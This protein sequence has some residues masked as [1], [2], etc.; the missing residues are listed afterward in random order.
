MGIS[1][2]G[3]HWG[4]WKGPQPAKERKQREVKPRIEEQF[5]DDTR[6]FTVREAAARLRVGA[7]TISKLCRRGRIPGA[8]QVGSSW[9]IDRNDLERWIEESKTRQIG[10]G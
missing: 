5:P 3:T 6:W 1:E 7:P 4:E 9:R 10:G 2:R 8:I